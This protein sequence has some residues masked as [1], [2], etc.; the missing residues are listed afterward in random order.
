MSTWGQMPTRH[1][2]EIDEEL[3]ALFALMPGFNTRVEHDI[4]G[5]VI[6]RILPAYYEFSTGC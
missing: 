6:S 2:A 3:L 4:T 5:K 1:G